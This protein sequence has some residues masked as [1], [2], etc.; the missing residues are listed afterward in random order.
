MTVTDKIS[1]QDVFEKSR[2]IKTFDQQYINKKNWIGP[3]L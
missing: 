1:N 2:Q 3:T